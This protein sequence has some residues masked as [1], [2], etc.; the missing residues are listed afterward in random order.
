M[1]NS[2]LENVVDIDERLAELEREKEQRMKAKGYE[3]LYHF[4]EGETTFTIDDSVP[5]RRADFENSSRTIC[6]ITVNDT[7]YNCALS[8]KIEPQILKLFKQG[9]RT[10]TLIRTGEGK[11]DTRYSLKKKK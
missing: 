5:F 10:F 3:K 7:K 2:T 4:E 11:T 1:S 8:P 9:Q 6:R